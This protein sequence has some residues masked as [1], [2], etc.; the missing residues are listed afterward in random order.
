VRSDVTYWI[1]STDL[2][3][4]AGDVMGPASA[5][6][7]NVVS[8]SGSS[9]KTVAD[10]GKALP[11]GAIVGTSDSQ[12]LTGK[13]IS[14]ANNTLTVRLTSDVTGNLPVARLGGGSGASTATFWR[15]DGTWATPVA[16]TSSGG[17]STRNFVYAA[18]ATGA[19]LSMAAASGDDFLQID[20]SGAIAA[21][22]VVLPSSPHDGVLFEIATSQ[23]ITALTVSS[24]D[25][26][27]V[28]GSSFSLL[29]NGG[30]GWWY[31]AA[32]SRW[33]RT[34]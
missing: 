12:T 27:T 32:N 22:N 7:G 16:T 30:A 31:R 8:F 25:S 13:I 24:P 1:S 4:G 17:A 29:A 5:V 20:P 9:G 11:A 3:G 23:A 6:A 33:Y 34:Y 14:G 10:S 15:G 26:S 2:L 21:L 28:N 18:P 19:T